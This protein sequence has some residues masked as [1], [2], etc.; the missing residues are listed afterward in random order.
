MV[1]EGFVECC[2]SLRIEPEVEKMFEDIV[3]CRPEHLARLMADHTKLD[4]RPSLKRISIPC[5]NTIGCHS[6]V[7]PAEGC[8]AVSNL[9][10]GDSLFTFLFS[11]APVPHGSTI[12]P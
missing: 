7:F 10:P 4:W 9:I 1:L 3:K 2:V 6:G 12:V 11:L 8:E 5:L